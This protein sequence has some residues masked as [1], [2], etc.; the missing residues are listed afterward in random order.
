MARKIQISNQSPNPD[1]SLEW[2]DLTT[3]ML[4][5]NHELLIRRA[6]R[7][8]RGLNR[9]VEMINA[10]SETINTEA[11]IYTEVEM[12]NID[13]SMTI[14]KAIAMASR[15]I[16]FHHAPPLL[17][18]RLPRS[19]KESSNLDPLCLPRCPPQTRY[20]IAN[21]VTNPWLAQ[22]HMAKFS[23]PSISTHEIKL[24]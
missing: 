1:S 18:E 2:H 21:L 19:S 14:M 6:K 17:L 4:P 7:M 20:I 13:D 15:K 8:C 3:A 10:E 16:A 24:P 23:K 9:E 5:T 12:I 11:E 22:A